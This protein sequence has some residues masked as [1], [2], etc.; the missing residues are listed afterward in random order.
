MTPGGDVWRGFAAAKELDAVS[1]GIVLIALPG[2]TRGHAGVAVDTGD[3][4]ILHCGDAFYHRGTID[5]HT[6]VPASLRVQEAFS[7]Y[8]WKQLRDNR[9][10]LAELYQR[11]EP[12]LLMICSHDSVIYERARKRQ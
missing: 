3:G 9:S 1:P 8:D 6:P 2:H 11:G 7:T 12:D 5:R 4:W 10:R